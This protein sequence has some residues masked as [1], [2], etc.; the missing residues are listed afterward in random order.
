MVSVV[1]LPVRN[2]SLDAPLMQRVMAFPPMV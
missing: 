2:T 1:V